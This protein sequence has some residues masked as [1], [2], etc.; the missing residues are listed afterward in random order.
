MESSYP[1]S[2][3]LDSSL[4]SVFS[5]L[6]GALRV[7]Y[8]SE[9]GKYMFLSTSHSNFQCSVSQT[10]HRAQLMAVKTLEVVNGEWILWIFFGMFFF[11][12]L[13]SC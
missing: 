12:W 6:T 10:C 8:T 4:F 7:W 3:Y 11:D 9:A 2:S 5:I 13:L 1:G